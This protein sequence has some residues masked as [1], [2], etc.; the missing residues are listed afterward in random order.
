MQHLPLKL[1][2]VL[3]KS[4]GHCAIVLVF[5]SAIISLQAQ[6]E[7]NADFDS[8]LQ[9][10]ENAWPKNYTEIHSIFS[11]FVSD[12]VI[13]KRLAVKASDAHSLEVESYAFNKLGEIYRNK[14]L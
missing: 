12:S 8:V 5:F 1:I 13:M 14:S 7:R 10:V 3:K 9:K 4:F 2:A 11:G 6:N